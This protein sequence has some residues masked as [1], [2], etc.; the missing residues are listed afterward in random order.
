[1][2]RR[3]AVAAAVFVSLALSSC[4]VNDGGMISE[5]R[6]LMGT[7]VEI[8]VPRGGNI[9]ENGTRELI[10]DAFSEMSR[11]ESVFSAHLPDSGLSRLNRSTTGVPTEVSEE[12]FALIQRSVQMGKASSGAFDITV[13][14]LID[15]WKAVR[16]KGALPTEAELNNALSS[17]G[18]EYLRLDP[19]SRTVTFMKHGMSI[20]MGGV[21]K[22]YAVS[23]AAGVLRAGG[24][25]SAIIHA[26]GDMYCL[27]RRSNMAKWKVGIQHPRNKQRIVFR[28]PLSD[29]SI[30]TS[31]D[32]ERFFLLNGKRYSHIIDPRSGYPTGEY[33]VSATVVTDDPAYGDMLSTA[34]SVLG[35]DALVRGSFADNSD[36]MMIVNEAGSLRA[37][38]T[39]GFIKR[40]GDVKKIPF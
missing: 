34:L 7:I 21:A 20:D 9:A 37:I 22:G 15:L 27:G 12:M 39:R 40:F 32:Y 17:V 33:V 10:H 24:I 1:M 26:G 8:R 23:R 6:M 11:V 38:A 5:T 19:A 3:S 36:A 18:S 14:P 25:H 31:G 2:I 35:P 29:A 13:K 4:S 16:I 28:L 30:D